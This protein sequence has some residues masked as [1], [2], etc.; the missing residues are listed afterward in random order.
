M[1]ILTGRNHH[2]FKFARLTDAASLVKVSAGVNTQKMTW[3]RTWRPRLSRI[4]Y[5]TQSF[6]P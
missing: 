5:A 1:N 4:P 3:L 6:V 2:S